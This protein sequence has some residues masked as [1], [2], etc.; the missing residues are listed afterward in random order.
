M[1]CDR[2]EKEALKVN[3]ANSEDEKLCDDCHY[4]DLEKKPTE[5]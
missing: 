2:C 4:K 3:Q 5:E 1:K